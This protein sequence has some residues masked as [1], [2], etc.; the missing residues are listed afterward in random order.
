[1]STPASNLGTAA[2]LISTSLTLLQIVAASIPQTAAVGQ[3]AVDAAL[4][5]AAIANLLKVQGSPVT[6]EQLNSLHISKTW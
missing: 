5:E 1:M 3:V 6:W 4:I 2:T